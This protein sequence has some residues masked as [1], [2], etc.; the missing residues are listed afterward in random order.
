MTPEPISPASLQ[1]VTMSTMATDRDAGDSATMEGTSL[2]SLASNLGNYFDSSPDVPD[3]A[4]HVAHKAANGTGGNGN[5]QSEPD[6]G[7]DSYPLSSSDAW[8]PSDAAWQFLLCQQE[9]SYRAAAVAAR[10]KPAS[11]IPAGNMHGSDVVDQDSLCFIPNSRDE[12]CPRP[13]DLGQYSE[14]VRSDWRHMLDTIS[15]SLQSTD[16]SAG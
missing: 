14:G 15:E 8:P 3:A 5:C 2:A 6:A 13:V 10:Q 12:A 7:L 16:M 1:V 4:L 11:G 9:S